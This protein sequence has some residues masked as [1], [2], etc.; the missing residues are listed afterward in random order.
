MT[1]MARVVLLPPILRFGLV[2]GVGF[3]V[4]GGLLQLLVSLAGWG[5]IEARAVSFPAAVLATW[6]LHRR[7]TF[8]GQEGGGL[9]ASLARY[10][11]VSLLGTSVNFGVYSALVLG[12]ATKAANPMVPFAIASG[13][14]LVFNYLGSKHF[15]FRR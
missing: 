10:V 9:L 1:A 5:P 14:A 4:D 13:I 8:R 15:A 12:S 6:W 7:I 3:V 2:G 11:A